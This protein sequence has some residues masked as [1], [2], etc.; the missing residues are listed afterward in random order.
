MCGEVQVKNSRLISID[1]AR[2]GLVLTADVVSEGGQCLLP[3]GAILTEGTIESLRRRGISEVE[4]SG[5]EKRE[6]SEEELINARG[7]CKEAVE[8]RFPSTAREDPH[9]SALKETILEIESIRYLETGRAP[10]AASTQID[11][12]NE[13]PEPLKTKD[14]DLDSFIRSLDELPVLP[15]VVVEVNRLLQSEDVLIEEVSA[16][17]EKDAGL[18]AKILRLA[19]S[20]YYG[21][22]YHVDTLSRALTVLGLN[23]VRNLAMAL[24]L[25][26]VIGDD[27]GEREEVVGLWGH[28]LG[29]AVSSKALIS[30]KTPK[31][32]EK[33]FICG[34][35][36]DIGKVVLYKNFKKEMEMIWN[37]V[38]AGG[39]EEELERMTFG[40]SHAEVGGALSKRWHFPEE[41]TEAIIKHAG[42]EGIR[43]RDPLMVSVHAGNQIARALGLGVSVERKVAMVDPECWNILGITPPEL[44]EITKKVNRAYTDLLSAWDV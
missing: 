18:T 28:S 16:L 13:P 25:H 44:S 41:L 35:L 3:A 12:S 4:V 30:V 29:T 8:N 5:E 7:I 20:S 31:L 39:E 15:E 24:A 37:T 38:K 36:H 22:S 26:G 14:A 23:T 43:R 17:V 9:L 1:D 10:N 40:F 32:E 33:A 21:L 6:Y 19:N 42:D 27:P 11:F 34:L 2:E